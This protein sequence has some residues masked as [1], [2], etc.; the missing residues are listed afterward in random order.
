LPLN[1]RISQEGLRGIGCPRAVLISP[2]GPGCH[3]LPVLSHDEEFY[4]PHAA[5]MSAALDN[6]MPAPIGFFCV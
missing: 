3:E 6:E 4:N 5:A 1:R 2:T